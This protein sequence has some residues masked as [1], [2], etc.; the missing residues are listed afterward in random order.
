MP[1]AAIDHTFHIE[2]VIA[3]QHGGG[4]DPENLAL[5]CD[6]CNLRKGTNLSS[7]DPETGDAVQL[8]H[9]RKQ[10]WE[11]HFEL[12]GAVIVGKGPIGRATARLLDM[13]A[14]RRVQLRSALL[15]AS[16]F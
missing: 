6:R 11:E 1:Q 5:A 13:N 16:E 8:F 14:T 7:L 12:R 15:E 3:R 4:D 9:P 10:E 2:H